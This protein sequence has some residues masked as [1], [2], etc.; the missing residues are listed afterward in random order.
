MLRLYWDI[1]S[2][3]F[4]DCFLSTKTAKLG[5]SSG[6]KHRLILTFRR[7]R[8]F[9]NFGNGLNQNYFSLR[10]GLLLRFIKQTK[11]FKKTKVVRLMLAMYLR[12][13]LIVSRLTSF[14]LWLRRLPI[15]M[16]EFLDALHRHTP[17]SFKDPITSKT[18]TES[19][20]DKFVFQVT[21]MVFQYNKPFGFMKNR[22]RGRVKRKISKRIVRM[23]SR[24]D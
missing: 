12:R 6:S 21:Y 8:I 14:D 24:V 15:F 16:Q 19:E 22:L 5:D 7:S 23:Q 2:R 3:P 4:R 18:V 10:P 1:A 11:A 20:S 13:L 17:V 9:V